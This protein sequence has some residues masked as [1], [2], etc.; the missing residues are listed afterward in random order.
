MKIL[1]VDDQ[2]LFLESLK[3]VI[4]NLA[5]DMKVISL[6]G[7]GKEAIAKVEEEKPDL[8]LMDVR[9]PV[10]DGVA[11]T[12]IIKKIYPKVHIIML[13]TFEDDEY[14]KEALLNG[15]AGYML[16]N[17]PP[18]MLISSIRAVASGAILISPSVAGTLLE[19]VSHRKP[20]GDKVAKEDIPH[21]YKELNH[22]EKEILKLLVDGKTNSEIADTIY[23][24]PQT[25]RNYISVIYSKLDVKNRAEAIRK[26]LEFDI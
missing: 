10:M 21:W 12:K 1:L 14:V 9:M 20:L 16:K 17:I 24:G 23:V 3:I 6:A 11:A 2:L 18:E 13:T 8:I 25:V 19:N 7:N 15:A 5:S 22:K 4:E 26:A